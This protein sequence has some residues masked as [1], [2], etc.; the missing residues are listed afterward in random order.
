MGDTA[1]PNVMTAVLTSYCQRGT[2]GII[3]LNNSERT[4]AYEKLGVIV[5][6]R[7]ASSHGIGNVE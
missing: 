6:E 5:V 3:R 7:I 2:W 4:S 1:S